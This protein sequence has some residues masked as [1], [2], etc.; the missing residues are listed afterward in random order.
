M[1]E[2]FL[3]IVFAIMGVVMFVIGRIA[4]KETKDEYG[5]DLAIIMAV[6]FWLCGACFFVSGFCVIAE[7]VRCF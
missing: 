7:G 4:Y 6:V 2:I 5:W 1:I 3:F